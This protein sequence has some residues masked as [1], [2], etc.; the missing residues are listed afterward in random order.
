MTER[1]SVMEA[2]ATRRYEYFKA[3]LL[4][5]GQGYAGRSDEDMASA[6]VPRKRKYTTKADDGIG[7]T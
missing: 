7:K 3:N 4:K 1:K 2:T 5:P 6:S